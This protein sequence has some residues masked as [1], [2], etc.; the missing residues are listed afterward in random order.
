[1]SRNRN[2]SASTIHHVSNL[3]SFQGSFQKVKSRNSPGTTSMKSGLRSKSW[4]IKWI[5]LGRFAWKLGKTKTC[6]IT[7]DLRFQ[8]RADV[9]DK[10]RFWGM[11]IFIFFA[12]IRG[13]INSGTPHVKTK[14]GTSRVSRVSVSGYDQNG[15]NV[16]SS[17][18]RGLH[19][20]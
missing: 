15:M 18:T 8:N 7:S 20:S 3:H 10:V 14:L 4:R 16:L 2:N 5:K 6:K 9:H 11:I 19:W 12:M 1:M 13:G 17:T